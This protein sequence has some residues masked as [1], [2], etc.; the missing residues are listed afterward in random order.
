[1]PRGVATT[2]GRVRPHAAVSV[3]PPQGPAPAGAIAAAAGAGAPPSNAA[4]GW[5]ADTSG[6]SAASAYVTGST[7]R[8]ARVIPLGAHDALRGVLTS[9]SLAL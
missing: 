6:T 8:D 7:A 3:P 1:M 5:F 4:G 9:V 2:G